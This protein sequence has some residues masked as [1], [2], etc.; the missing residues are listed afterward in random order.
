V[1][2]LIAKGG[3]A[4]HEICITP[5]HDAVKSAL[6]AKGVGFLEL[7]ARRVDPGKAEPGVRLG[8][9]RR[10]NGLALLIHPK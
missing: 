6:V 5:V 9:M 2:D 10:I 3:I 7:E 4:S 1:Q 8:S